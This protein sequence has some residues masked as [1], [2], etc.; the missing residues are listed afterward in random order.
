VHGAG[1][2]ATRWPMEN[3]RSLRLTTFPNVEDG[4]RPRP[5]KAHTSR[6]HT[7]FLTRTAGHWT[8]EIGTA[9]TI[10][11]SGLATPRGCVVE[12]NKP[13]WAVVT[14]GNAREAALA[15]RTRKNFG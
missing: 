11:L 10:A 9:S 5:N 6:N 1:A 15:S 8:L 3:Q 12:W 4:P 13:S 2:G 14:K 7:P